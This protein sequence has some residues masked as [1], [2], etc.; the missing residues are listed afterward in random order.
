MGVL[1][2]PLGT[3]RVDLDAPAGRAPVAARP[4]PWGGRVPSSG[5]QHDRPPSPMPTPATSLPDVDLVE[6]ARAGDR[7]AFEELVRRH[8][9]RMRGLAYRLLADRHAMDDAL[10]EAY[11]KAYRA[12]DR[13]KPGS[14]FGTWLYRITYNACIDE[15]RK[16][17]RAPVS[18][19]DP[20]DPTSGRPGPDRVVT[21]SET[22]RGAL[23]A[24]PVDQ[25]VTVVLV[26]GEGFDHREAAKI[27]GVA[28]GTVASR[29]HRARAA[30]RRVLGEEV[31]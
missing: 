1:T 8:D 11:L 30:L 18:T 17:K 4:V 5:G 25:R 19:E 22:V 27:L 13:F 24:L 28:P 23:A 7:S 31:P 14:D 9:D 15:L 3:P 12:L 2:P 10:Q 29:L 20:D 16:R 21:A 6:R 26:D